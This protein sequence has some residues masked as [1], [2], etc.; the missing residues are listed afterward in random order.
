M[1]KTGKKLT[2]VFAPAVTPFKNDQLLTDA[3]EGNIE[4]LNQTDIKGYLVLGSNGEFR[5]LSEREQYEVLS[6]FARNKA[7]KVLI[8]GCGCESTI[9]TS[10]KTRIAADLGYDFNLVL[11]PHYF[12]KRMSEDSII[13]HYERVAASSP[14][15][16]I[17]YNAPG[18]AA[19]VEITPQIFKHLSGHENIVGLKDSS[20]RGPNNFLAGIE[21]TS[22]IYVLAGSTNL[23]YPCLHLGSVGG[24]LSISN[25]LPNQ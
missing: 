25:F 3:L 12:N 20:S 19:G 14:I 15:P 6:V 7:G 18:Y 4:K 9:Q 1:N 11:P 2:G 5:S 21:S 10:E 23:F 22:K 13:E 24:V 16:I 17:L 8:A